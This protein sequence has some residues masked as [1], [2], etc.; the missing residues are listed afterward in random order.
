MLNVLLH[1]L[2]KQCELDVLIIG[3]FHDGE[4]RSRLKQSMSGRADAEL[5]RCKL[6]NDFVLQHVLQ[7]TPE[8]QF[9]G[10]VHGVQRTAQK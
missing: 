7:A 6:M 9:A 4:D 3:S 5:S 2:L 10:T 1:H 8:P